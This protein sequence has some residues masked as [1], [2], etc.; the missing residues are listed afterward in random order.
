MV[1][2]IYRYI[3]KKNNGTLERKTKLN[4]KYIEKEDRTNEIEEVQ[5][6]QHLSNL[7]KII[8]INFIVYSIG[9]TINFLLLLL[10]NYDNPSISESKT[11]KKKNNYYN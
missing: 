7:Y 4:N 5:K 3:D 9:N 6:N 8:Y 10:L 2:T 1:Q 11:N